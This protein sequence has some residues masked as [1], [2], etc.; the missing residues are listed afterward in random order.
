MG[1]VEFSLKEISRSI[2]AV[3]GGIAEW[4]PVFVAWPRLNRQTSK[5]HRGAREPKCEDR[6]SR[7]RTLRRRRSRIFEFRR[8]QAASDGERGARLVYFTFVSC[9]LMAAA[10]LT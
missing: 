6:L 9:T 2:F 8:T 7:R 3:G 5:R 1:Y 10:F 4:A